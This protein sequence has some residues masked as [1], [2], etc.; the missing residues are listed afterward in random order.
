[1][2]HR[3]VTLSGFSMSATEITQGQYRSI[4]GENP[5]R[6]TGEDNLP[7]ERVT[8]RDAV[9]F[10]N[11]LSGKAGFERCYD[12]G[13]GTYNFEKN[14]FR[15]PTAA[16]WEY[17]CRAGTDTRYYTGESPSPLKEMPPSWADSIDS[18][19]DLGRAGWYS[20]NSG[21]RNL[22]PFFL[23]IKT[24]V[25]AKCRSHPVGGK[26]PN[27]WGLYDMLGNVYEW[28]NDWYG[29]Y[30]PEDVTDPAGPRKGSYRVKRGGGR[31][32][33]SN[34]CTSFGRSGN[35]PDTRNS[36]LGF[37]VARRNH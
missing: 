16:E 31:G 4:M 19:S 35:K 34:R 17:A 10:C 11:R 14:G 28:C 22:T 6:F 23:D 9:R 12:E 30:S 21:D 29:N 20:G 15:L 5:S 7:V 26:V 27:A 37:R 18:T 13:N 32:S 33:Y 24:L 25:E 3:T 1:M 2:Y 36:D 8:W